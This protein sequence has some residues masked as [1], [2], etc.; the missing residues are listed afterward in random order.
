MMAS[1]QTPYV[2]AQNADSFDLW[3]RTKVR[4]ADSGL[5]FARSWHFWLSGFSVFSKICPGFGS[6]FR[7]FVSNLKWCILLIDGQ[8]DH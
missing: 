4:Y 8:F 5:E 6:G 1:W 7:S 3:A 2:R